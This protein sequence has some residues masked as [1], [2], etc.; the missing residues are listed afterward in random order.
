MTLRR[1]GRAVLEEVR[2]RV[3]DASCTAFVGRSGAGKS[4]LLRLLTRL[5]DPD[6]GEITFRGR[7]LA[8]LDALDLRRR[9]QLVSQHPVLL[10]ESV[11]D[12]IRIGCPH[13]DEDDVAGLLHRVAL[14][15]SFTQRT[16][17][18]LSGGEAQRLCLARALGLKPE[19]L[20]L[21]EPTAALDGRSATAIEAAV[22]DHIRQGGSAVLVSHDTDQVRRIADHVVVLD[23]GRVVADG[24]PSRISHSELF[25]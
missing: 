17:A 21:D 11:P 9:A 7:P 20:L 19:V 15:T 24:T 1:D 10:T 16:T 2:A 12:E 22:R 5:D 4:T 14:P 23:H 13:L 18:G 6:A 8:D 3:P 25:S